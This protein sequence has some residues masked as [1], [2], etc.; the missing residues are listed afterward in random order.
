MYHV[1]K[2]K[3]SLAYTSLNELLK[4]ITHVFFGGRKLL[5]RLYGQNI[6]AGLSS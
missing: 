6:P 4:K 3:T 2:T 5:R 1:M